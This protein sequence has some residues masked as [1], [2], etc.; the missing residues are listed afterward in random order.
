MRPGRVRPLAGSTPAPP[1]F[2][3]QSARRDADLY[4]HRMKR[5]TFSPV[6]RSPFLG[7][8][9]GKTDLRST[10]ELISRAFLRSTSAHLFRE[11]PF[12]AGL[13]PRQKSANS[14]G[15]FGPRGTTPRA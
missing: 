7:T 9:L 5:S 10:S 4:F 1:R 6:S 3:A 15:N 8:G 2:P 14:P 12:S 11:I 13:P